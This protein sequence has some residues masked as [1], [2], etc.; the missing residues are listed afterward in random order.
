MHEETLNS[1]IRRTVRE[2]VE[3]CGGN[4]SDAARRLGISRT[5]LQRLLSTSTPVNHL[6]TVQEM[7]EPA[8]AELHSS[9]DRRT[10]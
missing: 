5:R 4:K 8:A 7:K 1:I 10:A 2:M 9:P 3:R 6:Q